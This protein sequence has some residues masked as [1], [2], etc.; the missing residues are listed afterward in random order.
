MPDINFGE[1]IVIAVIALVVVGPRNL[2]ELAHKIGGWMREARAMATDFRVG[3]EREISELGDIQGDLKGLSA[4]ISKPLKEIKDELGSVSNEL[5]PLD[6]TGPITE[7]GPTPADAAED[8]KKIHGISDGGPVDAA[9][10]ISA[11]RAAKNEADLRDENGS[12]ALAADGPPR[13]EPDGT[14][15]DPDDEA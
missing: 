11:K 4:E 13:T 5:K 8:F 3:L 10:E 6:W 12:D 7:Q 2:P 14:E 15:P 1:W 9:P